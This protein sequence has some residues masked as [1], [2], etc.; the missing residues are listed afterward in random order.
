MKI[1]QMFL[2]QLENEATNSRKALERVPEGRNDWKPH[3][4]SMQLGYLAILVAIMPGWIASM[5]EQDNLEIGYGQAPTGAARKDLLKMLDES[6]AKARRALQSATDDHL[7][8][9]WQLLYKGNVIAED[10][11]YNMI[12]DVVFAHLAHHRGQL[13]VYLRLNDALV[14]ALYGGSADERL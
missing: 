11:R 12:R 6:V 14:P 10:S 7:M 4:K 5:I 1:A 9:R 2:D 8:T 13:T 3:P